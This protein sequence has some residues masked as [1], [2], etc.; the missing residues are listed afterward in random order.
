VPATINADDRAGRIP[1]EGA[2]IRFAFAKAPHLCGVPWVHRKALSHTAV[3][4][5][6][7]GVT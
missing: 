2:Q 7:P 1:I 3:G 6:F 5:W 4:N